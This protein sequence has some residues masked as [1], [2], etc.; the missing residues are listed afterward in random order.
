MNEQISNPGREPSS[1]DAVFAPDGT[2][3]KDLGREPSRR[4]IFMRAV[5]AAVVGAAGGRR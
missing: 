4:K 5:G 3:A 1:G 2:D